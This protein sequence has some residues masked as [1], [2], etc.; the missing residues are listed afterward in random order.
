V[1]GVPATAPVLAVALVGRGR[2]GAQTSTVVTRKQL[3]GRK[4][5]AGQC[6]QCYEAGLAYATSRKYCERCKLTLRR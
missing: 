3:R 4:R 6:V 2:R 5:P 1:R